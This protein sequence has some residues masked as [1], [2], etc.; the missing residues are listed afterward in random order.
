M[1]V[2]K[3]QTLGLLTRPFEFRREFWLGAAVLAFVPAGFATKLLMETAMWPFLAEELPPDQPLDAAMPKAQPEFLA[4]AHAFAPNGTPIPSLRVGIKLGPLVKTLHVFGDRYFHGSRAT[5]P[6]PF[7]TMPIDWAHAYGG[8]GYPDNPLGKGAVRIDGPD[9]PVTPIPNVVDPRQTEATYR[10]PASFGPIDQMWPARASKVGTHDDTWLQQDFPGFA[11]DIDWR[12]FNTAPPD[13]WLPKPLTGDEE[14]AFENLHPEQPLITGRLPGIAPRLFLVRKGQEDGFEEVPLAL[15]TVWFFPHRDRLV[16]VHHGRARLAEEDGADIA[17]AVIGAD[18]PDARRPPDAFRAVMNKRLA[19]KENPAAALR[20]QDL[21]PA[22]WLGPDPT[23]EAMQG[24]MAAMQRLMARQRKRAEREHADMVARVVSLGLDPKE[25]GP[26]PLPP[27]KPLPTLEELPEVLAAAQAEADAQR[28][29]GEAELAEREEA[30]RPVMEEAGLSLDEMRAK[31]KAKPKGPPEF[32]AAGI[33]RELTERAQSLRALGVV[34]SDLEAQLADPETETQWQK[35]EA[36]LRN[37][38]RLQA[39]QQDPADAAPEER[40]QEIRRLVAEDTAAARALYDLHGV[41]LAGLDLSG[42]DLSGVTLDGADLTGTSLVGARLTNAVLAHARME[43]CRLDQADLTGANLGKA[44]LSGASLRKTV[45]KQAVLA[46]ADLTGASLSGAD[47]EGADL[48]EAVTAGADF[49]AVHAPKI[50]ALKLDLRGFHAPGAVLTNAKFLECDLEKADF[51]GGSMEK[52]VFLKS[53]LTGM[54]L[55]GAR[56]RKAVF[57][58]QC[59]LAA[60]DLSGAD[61]TAANLRETELVGATLTGAILE[62]ADLSR[63]DLRQTS[64]EYVR[65]AGAR[66]VA[67]VLLYARMQGADFRQ[68]DLSR[69]DL[70]GADMR[71]VSVYEANLAR[72]RLDS[73]TRRGNMFMTRMRYLPRYV[74]QPEPQA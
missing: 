55:T 18:P 42:I 39:H 43:N 8:Q 24:P 20:D 67:A 22:E 29:K 5:Q 21:V 59:R 60:A 64:L 61:L 36:E 27:E 16:L 4:I 9:G 6:E 45:L 73:T 33:R 47:L 1:K 40:S 44:H 7:T 17:R 15:T 72:V 51:S 68:A 69:A 3:P 74:P 19:V 71:D 57:V 35:A 50:L 28:Q 34:A 11:R 32:T 46:G 10:F 58:E 13:Q 52:V 48:A 26:P 23:A 37:A 62:Q 54:K 14:Y 41:S 63:A 25:Y 56:M 12:F 49:S 66:L 2:I 53:N 65:A 70:R 38:Y 30:L 31:R